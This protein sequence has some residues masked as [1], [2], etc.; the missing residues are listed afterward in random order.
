MVSRS[1]DDSN[2]KTAFVFLLRCLLILTY[3]A[4][5]TFALSSRLSNSNRRLSS[6]RANNISAQYAPLLRRFALSRTRLLAAETSLI[7]DTKNETHKSAES[8]F[9]LAVPD[10]N[11]ATSPKVVSKLPA[12]AGLDR[13][14]GPLPPG[15]YKLIAEE[16]T[17]T[18]CLLAIGIRPPVNSDDGSVVW[19]EGARNCQKLIDSGFNTFL[20]NNLDADNLEDSIMLEKITKQRRR[21]QKSPIAVEK[22]RQKYRSLTTKIRHE[23]EENFYRVL[24]QNTPL[25]VLRSCHFMVTLEVPPILSTE[26]RKVEYEQS[27]LPFGNGWMVR[28]SVCDALKRTKG[29]TIGSLIL[30]RESAD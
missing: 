28:E 13:E 18:S 4:Y 27:T 6:S 25:S 23:A 16:D 15:A 9:W 8:T 12:I 21:T 29:E 22:Q 20:M 30:E 26:Q 3:V 1:G 10:T 2:K 7:L 19:E 5:F 17:I 24:R 14:S 11:A